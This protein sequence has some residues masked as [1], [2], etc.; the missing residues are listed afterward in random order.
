MLHL[1]V[2]TLPCPGP[3]IELRKQLEAGVREVELHVADDLAR[4]NVSRFARSRGAEPE[5][6]PHPAGGFLVTVRV[7]A[8]ADASSAPDGGDPE[9]LCAIPEP[10]A[11]H[12]P[13]IVQVTSDSMGHGDPA[14][15]ALLLRGYLKTLRDVQ[16]LP[17]MLVFYNAGARLCCEGSTSLE[18]LRA[19]AAEGVGVLACGT[20][21]NFYG[22]ADKLAVGRV[23]DMLEIAT[24]LATAGHVQRP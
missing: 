15:G 11:P 16:P 5:V 22:L 21:L 17:D 10:T 23:T 1:D 2:R 9:D 7:P 4:S 20:C 13:R 19:L 8:G 24:T 6:Q 12:G 3:V 18:D 14:L